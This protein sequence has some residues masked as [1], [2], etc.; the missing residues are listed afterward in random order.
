[1]HGQLKMQYLH[2]PSFVGDNY[3]VSLVIQGEAWVNYGGTI[4]EDDPLWDGEQCEDEC[5]SM[6]MLL[7][8]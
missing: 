6:H 4:F 2:A 3:S 8:C 1:M 7:L 5:C